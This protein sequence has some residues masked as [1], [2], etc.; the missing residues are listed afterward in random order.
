MGDV[1]AIT[2]HHDGLEP[3]E[4]RNESAV[5]NRLDVIRRGHL[6]NGWADIGYHFIVDPL[7]NAWEGRPLR[8]QGAHV[9]NNNPQNI[10]ILVLGHFNKQK[11]TQAA[12][13]TL[14]ELIVELMASHD[15]ALTRVQTHREIVST[16]C[17]GESLQRHMDRT[18]LSTGFV[19]SRRS[20][21]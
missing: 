8:F 18:R 10:G 6:R 20:R 21:I 7:G 11:P 4:L 19:G 16:A 5:R 12:K 14:D 2:V 9:R 15:V 3:V 13:D 1:R 17:P